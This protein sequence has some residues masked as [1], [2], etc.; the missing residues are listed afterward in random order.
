MKKVIM[1]LTEYNHDLGVEFT[2]GYNRALWDASEHILEAIELVKKCDHPQAFRSIGEIFDD[3]LLQEKLAKA[4][5][6]KYDEPKDDD[7][8][9]YEQDV[10]F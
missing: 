2:K 1:A 9:F 10:P 6:I 7:A 3:Y 5:G 4:L 8:P